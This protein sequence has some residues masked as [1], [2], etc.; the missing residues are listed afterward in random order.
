MALAVGVAHGLRLP[1]QVKRIRGLGLHAKC[2]F[3]GFDAGCQRFIRAA[4]RQRTSSSSAG[5]RRRSR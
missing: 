3:Q 4:L 5:G 1:V 2:R